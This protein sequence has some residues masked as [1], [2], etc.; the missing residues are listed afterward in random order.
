MASDNRLRARVSE[1]KLQ[2]IQTLAE[3]REIKE[4]DAER[5][6]VRAGLQRLGY[7]DE[8]VDPQERFLSIARKSGNLLGL[9]GLIVIGYG[10]FGSF[11]FRLLGFGLLLVG[12][13]TIAGAEFGPAV[14][15]RVFDDAGGEP[16]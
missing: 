4:T 11:A 13:G 6:V 16:A 14:Q 8:P 10:L 9:V 7:L 5:A 2:R 12:F 3:D 15:A 1:S